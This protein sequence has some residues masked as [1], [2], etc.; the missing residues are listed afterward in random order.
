MVRDRW[1]RYTCPMQGYEFTDQENIVIGATANRA[2]WWGWISLVCGV[3]LTLGALFSFTQSI[4][5]GLEALLQ[6]IPSVIVGAFFIKTAKSLQL[7]VDTQGDDVAHM[8]TAV[9]SLGAAFLV[10]LIVV[11]VAFVLGM[12]LGAAGSM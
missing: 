12:I 9:Q 11:G 8:M 6:G 4:G 1:F 7:V 2:K 10:Q 3:L 5:A